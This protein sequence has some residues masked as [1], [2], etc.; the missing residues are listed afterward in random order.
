[1]AAPISEINSDE[2]G[3][4]KNIRVVI[5]DDHPIVREALK[6]LLAGE[7][8]IKVVGEAGDG[9][10]ALDRVHELAP[11][12]LL[13]DLRM[14]N[15]DGFSVLRALLPSS[16]G[17]KVIVMTASDDK[18]EFVQAMRLG[19]L[20]IVHKQAPLPL[21][22][23]SIRKVNAGEIWLDSLTAT[24]VVSQSS[25]TTHSRTE[26]SKSY[27]QLPLSH[28]E[29]EIA[30]LVAQG[31]SNKEVAQKL[32]IAPQTVK[33]HLHSIFDKLGISDRVELALYIIH[34]GLHL[35]EEDISGR[36]CS[37]SEIRSRVPRTTHGVAPP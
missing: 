30:R 10:Q 7:E 36:R 21:V 6:T 5:A 28:R 34:R 32:F 37:A 35:E 33:N 20:G 27:G 4:R 25:S 8:D 16:G 22:V 19:C 17:M 26:Q 9:L 14:P 31:N 23:Q 24:P 18:Y 3:K 15:L 11:D 29:Q 12:V 13:L 1:M 2:S